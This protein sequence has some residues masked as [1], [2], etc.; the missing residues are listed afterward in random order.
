[1]TSE[2]V[3]LINSSTSAH[4]TFI[5]VPEGDHSGILNVDKFLTLEVVGLNGGNGDFIS[6]NNVMFIQ[7]DN[8]IKEIERT[9]KSGNL[10]FIF[11]QLAF[12]VGNL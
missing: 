2:E 1:M 6:R 8:K 7:V 12:Q 5:L 4:N 10:S 11:F 9:L 3:V